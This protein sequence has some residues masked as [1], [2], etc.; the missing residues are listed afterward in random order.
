[1]EARHFKRLYV[2][3]RPRNAIFVLSHRKDNYTIYNYVT[4]CMSNCH[5]VAFILLRFQSREGLTMQQLSTSHDW[6]LLRL[7]S[8]RA[9]YSGHT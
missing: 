6:V 8:D 4:G 7:G 2:E 3:L 9:T 1:M 5:I